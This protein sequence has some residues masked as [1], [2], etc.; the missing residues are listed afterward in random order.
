MSNA[1]S[2]SWRTSLDDRYAIPASLLLLVIGWSLDIITSVAASAFVPGVGESNPLMR[3]ADGKFDAAKALVIFLLQFFTFVLPI[4]AGLYIAT[5]NR[6]MA[7][8]PI[9]VIMWAKAGAIIQNVT[10]LIFY[11]RF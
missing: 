9:W 10:L 2:A 7:T 11:G 1:T 8:I 3:G 6:L 5:R 4:G